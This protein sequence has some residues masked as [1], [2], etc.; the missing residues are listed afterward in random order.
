ME[1]LDWCSLVHG[2]FQGP[3]AVKPFVP[4]KSLVRVH[5]QPWKLP[6]AALLGSSLRS[7]QQLCRFCW[8]V[9]EHAPANG[10]L[11]WAS[12]HPV[13]VRDDVRLCLFPG[14]RRCRFRFLGQISV[15]SGGGPSARDRASGLNQANISAWGRSSNRIHGA[16]S[17]FPPT[18]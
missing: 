14:F 12:C 3:N 11:R 9:L 10:I 17:N 16:K 2:L 5:R 7:S 1:R 6:Y 4:G 18:E 13:R 8:G 15:S